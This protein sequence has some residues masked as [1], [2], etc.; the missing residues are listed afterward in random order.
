MGAVQQWALGI[1]LTVLVN[2]VVHY[3]IPSGSMEKM[4]RLVLGAFV[5]CGILIP[6][7]QALPNLSFELEKPADT[8]YE[9][10]GFA[11]RVEQ[12][13]FE[14]AERN[15]RQV[16][17]ADLEKNRYPWE[18]V[19]V[20]MDRNGDGSIVI[21]RVIVTLDKDALVRRDEL[22]AHLEQT[23]GLKTEVV[24]NGESG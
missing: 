10:G 22:A 15:V 21:D 5:L 18:N 2:A 6:L 16:V 19:S 3:V 7:A 9:Y 17:I 1:C 24:W 23:L 8:L 14:Q 13:M 11:D 20:R 4:L 12:E